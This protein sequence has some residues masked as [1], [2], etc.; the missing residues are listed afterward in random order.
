MFFKHK[1]KKTEECPWC[2]VQIENKFS[3]CPH[4]GF[5]LTDKEK[6]FKD[7]GI[8]GKRD[9]TDEEMIGKNIMPVNLGALD[10]MFFSIFNSLVKTM[11]QQIKQNDNVNIKSF[12]NGVKIKIGFQKPIKIQENKDENK[13]KVITEKQLKKIS[14]LPRVKAKTAMRR[15]GDSII[16]ELATPGITSPE[17]IFLAKLESGYE[18]KAIGNKKIYVNSLPINLPIKKIHL[19]NDKVLVEF[20]TQ[21]E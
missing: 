20:R 19:H 17:D 12:P 16:Y 15:I 6:E 9:L 7:F 5:S 1:S 18:I 11:D 14:E 4:C 13:V 8:L 2:N 3:F 21:E 10:K